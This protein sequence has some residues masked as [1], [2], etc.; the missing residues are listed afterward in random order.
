MIDLS[1]LMALGL[2][3]VRPGALILGSPA[4]GGSFAP[5]QVK[6]ALTVFLALG[7]MPVATVPQ[8]ESSVGLALIVGRELAIGLSLGLAVHALIAAAEMAGH[9]AGF[10]IG[11]SYSAIV[12]PASGVRNNVIASL[13]G[14]V[15]TIVF[16]I[17]NGHHAFLRAL[18]QSYV[19]LPMGAGHIGDSLPQAVM[20]I[21]GLVF[22]F[23]LRIAAPIIAVL[24]LTEIGLGLIARA[25]PALNVMAVGT[26][27]RLLV[28]LVLLGFVAPAAVGVFSGSLGHVLQLGVRFAEVFR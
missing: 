6:I 5:A 23:A 20:S 12:D 15:A 11:L 18:S 26:P 25:A 9:L 24:L 13:Y 19:S 8:A 28:G 10:Q 4:F 22:G 16:L 2:L 3:M 14:M 27:L 21:L 17:A 1:P 7:L